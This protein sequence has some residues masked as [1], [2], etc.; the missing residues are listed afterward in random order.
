MKNQV[1]FGGYSGYYLDP[2]ETARRMM[3]VIALH[4][5]VKNPEAM[6]LNTQWH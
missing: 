6:T 1:I 5:S 4:D 3:R 2:N